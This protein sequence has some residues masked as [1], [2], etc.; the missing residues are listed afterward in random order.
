MAIAVS[1]VAYRSVGVSGGR[2]V[3]IDVWSSVEAPG[4]S[5]A[6]RGP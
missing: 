5:I 3:V 2:D 4:P 1:A 6:S